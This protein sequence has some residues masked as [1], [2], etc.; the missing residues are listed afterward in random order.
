MKKLLSLTLVAIMVF[1]TFSAAIPVGAATYS[2]TCGDNLTWTLDTDTG[3][4]TI[5]GTGGM[6]DYYY[7]WSE[8]HVPWYDHVSLIKSVN[9]AYGVTTIGDFAFYE[10][11]QLTSFTIPGSVTSIGD[12]AFF[13]CYQL[14]SITIPD[15]VTSI[16]DNAF[17]S[18]SSLTS[19][20]IPDS[21]T[22][23][24]RG[25]FQDCSSLPSII[26]PNKVTSIGKYAFFCCS[27]LISIVIPDSV[28]LI[29]E[30]AFES[31]NELTSI[32]IGNGVPSIGNSAFSNCSS[33][34]SITVGESNTRYHSSGNCLI[35]TVSKTLVLGCKNSV[36]PSDGSVTSIGGN[37]FSHCYSLTSINIP[38]SVTT[39]GDNAFSGCSRLASITIPDGVTT[40][41]KYAFG[42]CR[43]LTSVTIPNSVTSIDA[44]AFSEC[45]SLTSIII[46][47]S[48][49][50][51][52]SM[53]FSYCDSLEYNVYDNAKYIGNENNPY[54]VLVSAIN[55]EIQLCSIN[56]NTRFISEYAFDGCA[57]LT[58]LTLPYSVTS[59]G[60]CAFY[61]CS[62]LTSITIPDGVTS[63]GEYAFYGC[64]S[65]RLNEYDG[66]EYLGN[67]ENP[68]VVLFKGSSLC[69][70][71]ENTRIIYERAFYW[72]SF[73]N[74]TIPKNVVYI[75]DYAF[76]FFE[77]ES[78]TVEDGNSK[79]SSVGNC[80]IDIDAGSIIVGCKNSV[81]PTDESVKSI[82]ESA[83]MGCFDLTDITI[84]ENI[85]SIGQDAFRYCGNLLSVVITKNV[86]SI[87]ELAF[88]SCNSLESI[89]VEEG[90]RRYHSY[91]NCVIE[92]GTKSLVF[93]CKNSVI[94][95]DG[96]VTSIERYAFYE[97][98]SL[99]SI[100]IPNG[101]KSIDQYAFDNC[102]SLKYVVLPKSIKYISSGVFKDCYSLTDVYYSGAEEQWNNMYFESGKDSLENATLHFITIL[103]GDA[104]GDGV[105]GAKDILNVKKFISLI[106]DLDEQSF[107]NADVNGDGYVNMKDVLA[108]MRIIAE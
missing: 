33:L 53:A 82:G 103:K 32:V 36:I 102:Y 87:G 95:S 42:N 26:I 74:L 105:V 11:Y 65:L 22:S 57:A 37:A 76:E 99:E 3:V 80:L 50:S 31:C 17:S 98:Y 84:P 71:N 51:I 106:V 92:T 85:K 93:G 107:I 34:E 75:G 24:G 20:T 12:D 61:G 5:S 4:L 25:V 64:T 14:T 67:A 39:I 40:I 6:D 1:A 86:E 18:C 28:T 35:E 54:L 15:S 44:C 8:A 63:I 108:T 91:G 58:S 21:V 62:S 45:D 72:C 79:Y 47:E 100:I 73:E 43:S 46:P 49:T 60:Y 30:S 77:S 2:G 68:C 16:G 7:G 78:I 23:I 52:G 27:S 89:T 19:I 13:N 59:I 69:G 83:F 29:G 81:I 55:T 101:V 66:A 96:S 90:N 10:C 104:D 48:V 38:D 70:I 56:D 41:G 97:C 88:G 94:P 9:I